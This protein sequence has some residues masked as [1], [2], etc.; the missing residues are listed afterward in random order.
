M[1]GFTPNDAVYGPPKQ[2][3]PPR[4]KGGRTPREDIGKASQSKGK[5][6]KKTQPAADADPAAVT[7]SA[8]TPAS[9]QANIGFQAWKDRFKALK[10]TS[11]RWSVFDV[12]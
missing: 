7:S 9:K 10:R 5:G 12:G 4:K 2:A 6:N 3:T 11:L 8:E 1:V